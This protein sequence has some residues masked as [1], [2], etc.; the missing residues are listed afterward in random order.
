MGLL[1][2]L[3]GGRKVDAPASRTLTYRVGVNETCRTLAQRFYGNEARWAE[4]YEAN[5]RILKNEVQVGTDALPPGTEISILAPEFGLDGKPLA[6]A[7][8]V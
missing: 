4:I 5:E 2:R 8:T 3:F 7:T 6:P 1:G